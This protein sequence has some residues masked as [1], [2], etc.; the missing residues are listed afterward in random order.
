MKPP[1]L[2]LLLLCFTACPE[3]ATIEHGVQLTYTLAQEDAV[4]RAVVDKR[5]ARLRLAAKLHEQPRRLTVRGAA[6]DMPTIKALLAFPA[7]LE[8]CTGALDGGTCITPHV[9]TAEV[10]GA[11]LLL[12]FDRAG[13]AELTRV[14]SA[15]LDQP[16]R[17]RLDERELL[18]ATLSTPLEGGKL[19]IPS[20]LNVDPELACAALVGGPLPSL[21]LE[22]E[23]AY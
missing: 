11:Q 16:L 5:L 3:R 21:A 9:V 8:L 6:A 22:S 17:V 19:F 7:K 10:R 14:T 13:A 2:L 12:T 4:P 23:R 1:L 15:A 18:S 20:P